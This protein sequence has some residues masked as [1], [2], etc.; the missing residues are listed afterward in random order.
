VLHHHLWLLDD[1]PATAWLERLAE[2]ERL[3]V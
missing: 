1:P 2:G 3:A